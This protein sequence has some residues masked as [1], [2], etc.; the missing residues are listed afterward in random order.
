MNKPL[1]GDDS[2]PARGSLLLTPTSQVKTT[3]AT[4]IAVLVASF[5]CG[6]L[7]MSIKNDIANLTNDRTR[8]RKD[9]DE[10]RAVVFAPVQRAVSTNPRT[11]PKVAT[12]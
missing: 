2:S 4:L 9:L 12:P 7:L 8:D 11:E 5:T 3:Q 6:G 10:V 1:P